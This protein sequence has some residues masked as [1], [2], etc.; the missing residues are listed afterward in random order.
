VK[1]I[2]DPQGNVVTRYGKTV[3]RQL[4]IDPAHLQAVQQGMR[5]SVANGAA[6]S[7][8]RPGVEIAGKTGTAEFGE[9]IGNRVY[10]THGWFMGYTPATD[11]DIA[12]AVFFEQGAGAASA[13]PTGGKILEYY[14]KNIKPKHP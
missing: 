14:A 12:V 1:E 9:A 7:A 11:P 3:Q 2:Q 5:E 13:A 10:E 4:A 8:Q 6:T